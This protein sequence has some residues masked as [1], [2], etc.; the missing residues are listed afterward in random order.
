MPRPTRPTRHVVHVAQQVGECVGAPPRVVG[1]HAREV[2]PIGIDV[3]AQQCHLK[4]EEGRAYKEDYDGSRASAGV[5]ERGRSRR[6]LELPPRSPW[7]LERGRR[8]SPLEQSS[9][10]GLRP[11]QRMWPL[12]QEAA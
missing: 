12:A 11:R 5:K 6:G 8:S 4:S 9:P 7:R 10:E 1:R 3:L 2:A